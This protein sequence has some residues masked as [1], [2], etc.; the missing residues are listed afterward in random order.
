MPFVLPKVDPFTELLRPRTRSERESALASY[1]P[2]VLVDTPLVP[3]AGEPF[4]LRG[5]GR[6]IKDLLVSDD[7]RDALLD[8]AGPLASPVGMA[9]TIARNM[10]ERAVEA[11]RKGQGLTRKMSDALFVLPDGKMVGGGGYLRSQHPAIA[12]RAMG[13]AGSKGVGKASDQAILSKF[14]KT[15]GSVRTEFGNLGTGKSFVAQVTDAQ[16]VTSEQVQRLAAMSRAARREGMDT[17]VEK[18]R[19]S[20]FRSQNRDA[21]VSDYITDMGK[22]KPLSEQQL[23]KFFK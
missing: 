18:S 20:A 9:K 1:S 21:R 17:Y 5:L 12:R 19:P 3:G 13:E 11:V 23:R 16:K 22:D 15:S 7:P 14:L 8:L 2:S 10:G 6:G 4:S